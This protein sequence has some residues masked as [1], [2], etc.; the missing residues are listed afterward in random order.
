MTD[1]NSLRFTEPTAAL[2]TPTGRGAIAAIRFHGDCRLIA[3][4]RER[5]FRSA[6][7][8]A[9]A[10]ETIGRVL[11]GRWGKETTEEVVL[12]RVDDTT[13]EIH[14]HGGITAAERILADLES[15]GCS[16]CT[17]QELTAASLGLFAAECTEALAR[18]STLRTAGILLEQ[19]S[20]VL[21]AA[22][23]SLLAGEAGSGRSSAT[24]NGVRTQTAAQDREPTPSAVRAV[25]SSDSRQQIREKLDELLAWS[26]FGMHLAQPWRVVLAGRPNVGKSSLINALVGYTRSIVFDRPG[27]TRDVV[28][29]ETA[30]EGW[31][32]ELADTA[33]LRSGSDH[34]ESAGIDRTRKMLADADCRVL[35]FDVSGP[36]HTEDRN[37]L[38]EWPRAILVAHKCD[39]PDTWG[40]EVPPEAVRVSSLTGE[41][42]EQFANVLSRRLVPVVPPA[43]TPIPFT[44]RQVTLLGEARQAIDSNDDVPFREA[45]K[46]LLL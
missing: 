20:G 38:A 14:C 31:P 27:T 17:W 23:E 16:I 8:R 40:D 22:V 6:S 33:G 36:P 19:H 44:L 4:S 30:L 34:L 12:C 24:S 18:C 26:E 28:T 35:L 15:R 32:I 43:G 21:K 7:G 10:E 11:F 1:Q 42:V 41:G 3:D 37:L 39:L 45:L 5:L 46:T 9:L 13:L 29:A 2:L 25:N